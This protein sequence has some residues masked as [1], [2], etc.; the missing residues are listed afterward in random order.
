MAQEEVVAEHRRALLQPPLRRLEVGV[1]EEL[2]EDERDRVGEGG[3]LDG[4]GTDEVSDLVAAARVGDDGDGEVA[5]QVRRVHLQRLRV[6]VLHEEVAHHRAAVLMVAKQEER[7]V[8]QPAPLLQEHRGRR[9]RARVDG[10]AQRVHVVERTIPVLRQDLAR[11]LAPQRREGRL[12]VGRQ[13]ARNC[14]SKSAAAR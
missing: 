14:A 5:Q 2:L 8:H 4:D 13:R 11:E 1:R 9:G 6:L 10:V 3:P 7:P 12:G